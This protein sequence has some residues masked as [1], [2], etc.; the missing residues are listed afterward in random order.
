MSRIL[1]FNCGSSGLKWSQLA[2]KDAALLGGGRE[3]WPGGGFGGAEVGDTAG[4]LFRRLGRVDAVAHRFV[5]GGP[6]WRHT[7][8]MTPAVRADLGEVATLDPLHMLPALAVFDAV[9]AIKPGLPHF[10]SFDTAFHAT[11]PAAASSYALPYE[12]TER[13]DLRRLGFH[14]L[15]VDW[16]VRRAT[17][18]HGVLPPRM[19][20]VHLGSGCSVTAVLDGRSVDTTMGFTPVEGLVMATRSG[21]VDP[22]LLLHLQIRHGI[23]AP[24]LFEA[25][26]TRSGLLGVSGLSADLRD[27][28]ASADAGL[29]RS[30][31]AYGQFIRSVRRAIGGMSAVLG[32]VDALVFTGGIGEHLARVR[33]DATST[34]EYAGI[35]L[36]RDANADA[37][38]DAEISPPEAP[39]RVLVVRAREDLVILDDVRHVMAAAAAGPAVS[40]PAPSDAP[41]PAP[42][43]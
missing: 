14:G 26:N 27:V 8:R 4:A 31:L 13:W 42:P 32:G 24:E 1:V 41:R 35:R 2:V 17:V 38:D 12:W 3:A 22:G 15:S 28:L 29:P 25:L 39:I 6:R 21:S 23:T 5:H 16:A 40:G 30:G 9:S 43:A 11:L 37:Q 19:I 36:D 33:D 34:L 20:V 18:M 10:A 7:V